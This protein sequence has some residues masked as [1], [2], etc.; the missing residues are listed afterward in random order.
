MDQLR[1]I[2]LGV[3]VAVI[4]AIYFLSRNRRKAQQNSPLDAANE[5]PSFSAE[6]E[7]VNDWVDGVG[8]VRVVSHSDQEVIESFQDEIAAPEALD[9][10]N[11][12]PGNMDE[13]YELDHEVPDAELIPEETPEPEA[14]PE[15]ETLQFEDIDAQGEN[16]DQAV[17]DVIAVF[18]LASAN[19]PAIKGEKILSASYGLELEHGDMRI[20]HRYA[21]SSDTSNKEILFSMANMMEPGWFDI[22]E[23]HNIETQGVS[24]FMQ[25]NL[26]EHPSEV[27][28]EMLI[29]AHRMATMTGA[30][31]CNAQRKPLDEQHT[32]ELR[33]KVKRLTELKVQKA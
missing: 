26:V 19:E 17:D 30:Q 3:A 24:F 10:D 28:D 31:L 29:C 6:E 11:P 25:V 22:E 33:E 5:A 27:L 8:P 13:S 16:L 14:E 20:F 21:K 32:N 15:Q 2:L 1:W 12:F 23:M 4:V 7:P 9:V 18:V